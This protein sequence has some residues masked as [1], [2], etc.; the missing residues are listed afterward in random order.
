DLTDPDY[1]VRQLRHT[2]RFHDAVT[3]LHTQ[4]V[5]TYLELGPQAVLTPLVEDG[6]PE[7][8]LTVSV[9]RRDR[10]EP[11]ALTSALAAAH[12][13]GVV[14]DWAAFFGG[15]ARRV[16][17]PVYP[18][19]R[20]AFWLRSSTSVARLGHAGL[21][22]P[23]HPLLS[24]GVKLAGDAGGVYT[25]RL[26]L[27]EQPW[28]ADHAVHGTVLLPA[29]AFL[30]ILLRAGSD[31]GAGVVEDLSLSEPLVL[32]EH[33]AVVLQVAVGAAD[34]AGRRPVTVHS[35]AAD[36]ADE[37]EQEWARHATGTLAPAE[38][39]RPAG[40]QLEWPPPASATPVAAADAYEPLTAAGVDYGP[41]F[42]GL[43]A[44]WRHGDSL[45]AEV[46]L[47]EDAD[48]RGFG[49]HPALLDAC[50]H[51]LGVL[52]VDGESRLPVS[53]RGVALHTT[54][55]TSVRVLLAPTDEDTVTITVADPSGGVVLTV[56][57]L[58]V[59]PVARNQLPTARHDSLFRM[60]WTP[61][62]VR[63]G[64]APS[65]VAVV[66]SDAA[67]LAAAG[68]AQ[69]YPD[70]AALRAAID[71][72]AGVPGAVVAACL[73]DGA[74][75]GDPAAGAHR[76]TEAALG[77]VQ[78]WLGDER[79]D[80][81]RL[82]FASR[83]AVAVRPDEDVP[84][85]AEAAVW[86]LVRSAESENSGRFALLDT[87]DGAAPR[88]VRAAL[89]AGEPQLALRDGA[90]YAPR[91]TRTSARPDGSAPRLDPEG[92]VL[93]T[94]GTGALGALLARHVVTA[95]GVRRVLLV[96]RRGPGTPGAAELVATLREE[97]DAEVTVAACDVADRAALAALLDAI[98]A[99]HQ[100]T[101]VVHAA[102]VLNDATAV[103]LT[104][105]QLHA[106][107][108]PKA[109]AAWHLHELTRDLDLAAFVL[110]SSAAGA[111]G[112]PG[113]GNYA[114]ANTF[115][116][117]LASHRRAAG[118]PATSL[119][120]G[121]WAPGGG[122]AASLD[123][124]ALARSRRDGIL[125]LSA[126]EGLALFD[127]ALAMDEA[128][129]VPA[130]VDYAALRA[131]AEAGQ[132]PPLYQRLTRVTA[133]REPAA[134]GIPLA[135]RLV[136]RSAAERRDLVLDLVVAQIAA[137]LGHASPSGISPARAFTELGFDSLTAVELR[138][139]LGVA[140]GLKLP[141]TLIFDY[142]TPDALADYLVAEVT[143]AGAAAGDPDE[144]KF[145]EALAS[146]PFSRLKTSGVVELLLELTAS[147]GDESADG[148]GAIDDMNVD[149]LVQMAL[150]TTE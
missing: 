89:A 25:G 31:L 10:P 130:R 30:D 128:A 1:W 57:S 54:G 123:A 144:A 88:T 145:R 114:A 135:E 148:S 48:A 14:V 60:E 149:D 90:W 6:L 11:M 141:T 102:G 86:G 8:C 13:H 35:R 122:M 117:A 140:S 36:A 17:L 2:V 142:P 43:R 133:R 75:D 129:L 26:S 137:V 45:Y 52:Q 113:Q 33:G 9:M 138:N 47:P 125:P 80:G 23:D 44:A 146:L 74:A 147:A 38:A 50:L 20:E 107:L 101:A 4:G 126:E 79:F 93:I 108:R 29:A 97:L 132:L 15:P 7:E 103:R 68:L 111:T 61:A 78:E 99:E 76:A 16:G 77:L 124:T 49:I 21:E 27:D 58:V 64:A 136:S 28:L 83:H 71:A 62:A 87:D 81:A 120:W 51:A 3:T 39:A 110:F 106:V 53:W 91:L 82:F 85:L 143:P 109:D 105:D 73:P 37:A 134:D 98:P 41:V 119:A 115:L 100:L 59:R 46:T 19:Q 70:L 116:D 118:L 150:D 95:Y 121:M 67:G 22:T 127:T 63:E 96:G 32:P 40:Q 131:Q 92:T 69:S 34:D 72:G 18:F 112:N 12:A 66:G 42:R 84:G 139:R 94:G 104:P 24:A 65:S 55:A 56:E 5:T